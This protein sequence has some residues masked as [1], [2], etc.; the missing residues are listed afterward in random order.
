MKARGHVIAIL[1]E[2]H[3]ESRKDCYDLSSEADKAKATEEMED[4]LGRLHKSSYMHG[5]LRLARLT[6]LWKEMFY[7]HP[8]HKEVA[9]LLLQMGNQ[10]QWF[11]STHKFTS[12]KLTLTPSAVRVP[13]AGF[14]DEE[15]NGKA[16]METS[17]RAAPEDKLDEALHGLHVNADIH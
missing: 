12:S 3:G 1:G 5:A 4:L 2:I 11:P 10:Q 8:S 17:G 13:Y 7:N 15:D 16:D 6:L 9:T 14:A